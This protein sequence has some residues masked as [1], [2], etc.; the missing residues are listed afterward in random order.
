MH[1]DWRKWASA[2]GMRALKTFA[3]AMLAWLAL[4]Q[5][6]TGVLDVDWK[7]GL[8]IAALAA[9]ASVLTSLAGLPEVDKGSVSAGQR[10]DSGM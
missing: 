9:V 7:G 2:A 5:G 4:G 10:P 6:T 1:T 8:G 3:Q